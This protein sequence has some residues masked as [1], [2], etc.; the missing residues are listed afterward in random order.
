MRAATPNYC[1]G[2]PHNVSTRLLEG[3]VAW[4]SPGCHS[5][6]TIMEQPERQIVSMTQYGGEGLPWVG[7]APFTDRRHIVQNVGDGSLFHSSYLNLRYC[8][9]AGVNITFKILYN[10]FIANTGA[11]A[12]M[13]A[14]SVP[15]LAR[16]L[17]EEGVRRVAIVSKN[18]KAYRRAGLPAVARA[19]GLDQYERVVRALEREPGVTVLIYDE[20]CANER[21]RQRKR[22]KLPAPE[23]FVAINPEVCEACGHCG[24][25][26]N[27]MSLQKVETEFGPKTRV[28]QS[29]CNQDY[30]CLQGDW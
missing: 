13:G 26:T 22:A 19:Y 2:C 14:K 10:G 29:S 1:S 24:A 4:G 18:P 8:V 16:L 15:T 21:R 11:Q 28:H 3:Q 30:S 20:M 9:A 25:L 12:P 5:F 27:C 7:L 23:R 17:A 6:A